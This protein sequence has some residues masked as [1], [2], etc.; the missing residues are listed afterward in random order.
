MDAKTKIEF[1]LKSLGVKYVKEHRFHDKRKYRF[2]FA[3]PEKK[4]GIEYE[5]VFSTDKSRHTT[6]TGYTNDSSKYNLAVVCGWRV[7]RYTAK[8]VGE[9]YDDI[10]ALL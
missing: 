3:I 8:N 7:L 1:I 9:F 5:G 2:D 6:V 4:I 10:K